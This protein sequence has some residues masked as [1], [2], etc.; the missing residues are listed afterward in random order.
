M[1]IFIQ[2][3]VELHTQGMIIDAR[4]YTYGIALAQATKQPHL[5][6]GQK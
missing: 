3:F 4:V 6:E 1:K 5:E 2:C